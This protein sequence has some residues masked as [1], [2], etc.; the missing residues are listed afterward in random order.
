MKKTA[1]IS[2]I[3][4]NLE[5]LNAVLEAIKNKGISKVICLGDIIGYGPNPIECLNLLLKNNC[6]ILKGNHESM[7]LN[8]TSQDKCSSL[9][10]LSNKWTKQKISYELIPLF[11]NFPYFFQ[12]FPFLYVHSAYYH[13][14]KWPYIYKT[15]CI[16]E[17]FGELDY[18]AIFFGHTHRAQ[19]MTKEKNTGNISSEF[20]LDRKSIKLQNDKIYYI[21]V[22]SIGQPRDNSIKASFV[23]CSY[24]ENQIIIDFHRIDYDY[25]V[26]YNK[27]I[28]SG[29]GKEIA[30]FLVHNF[31]PYVISEVKK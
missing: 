21:N 15:S 22:G 4:G 11:K 5:A 9:A 27:I 8:E 17:A 12:E 19:I 3:H 31:Y 29:L 13:H 30:E 25:I 28:N 16:K 7:L 24:D 6:I 10:K 20:I 23:I 14:L 1:V 26:T 2:D 18:K